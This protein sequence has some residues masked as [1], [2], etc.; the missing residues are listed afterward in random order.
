MAHLH[1]GIE[2]VEH[3]FNGKALAAAYYN[4][5]LFFERVVGFIFTKDGFSIK[6][7]DGYTIKCKDQ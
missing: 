1:R 3:F 2:V 6:T 5:K 4:G 7:K